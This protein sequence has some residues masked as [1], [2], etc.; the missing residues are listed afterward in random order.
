MTRSKW[1]L[2]DIFREV[3]ITY[4]NKKSWKDNYFQSACRGQEFVI[5]ENDLIENW[6]INIIKENA[7][8]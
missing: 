6:A 8:R 3:S 5:E 2:P 1:E 7:R 4:H